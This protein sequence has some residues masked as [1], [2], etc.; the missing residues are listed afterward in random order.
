MLPLVNDSQSIALHHA[1]KLLERL[2]AVSY[3]FQTCW[4]VALLDCD[5]LWLCGHDARFTTAI[6]KQ[7][8]NLTFHNLVWERSGFAIL[9]RWC[10]KRE[11]TVA[12]PH[13]IALRC[14]LQRTF[15]KII[16][17]LPVLSSLFILLY[18]MLSFEKSEGNIAILL[19]LLQIKLAPIA[20]RWVRIEGAF[21]VARDS[22]GELIA[23]DVM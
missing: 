7:E 3:H 23:R 18:C 8:I 19:A 17:N 11:I 13:I 5:I 20:F 22:F 14:T 15:R 6:P 1:W 4:L 10:F 9:S 21:G 2:F 12:S 16:R